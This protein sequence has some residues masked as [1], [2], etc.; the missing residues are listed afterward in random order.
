MVAMWGRAEVE[1][2]LEDDFCG[3]DEAGTED[4][5]LK[6]G[7]EREELKRP[8]WLRPEGNRKLCDTVIR[9]CLS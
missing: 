8:R 6:C 9:P 2:D 7:V 3:F 4:D 5:D 1:L